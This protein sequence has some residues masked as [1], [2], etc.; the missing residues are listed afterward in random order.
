[1]IRILQIN[2]YDRILELWKRVPGVGLSEADSKERIALFLERN[3]RL[4]FVYEEAGK[5][6]GTILCG[7][8]GRRGYIYHLAVDESYRRQGIGKS[9]VEASLSKLKEEGI[10]KCHLFVF[11]GNT[12]GQEFWDKIGWEKR[13]DILVFSKIV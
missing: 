2:D 4:S 11:Q 10:D 9:L 7:H 5:I 12:L 13:K 3:K 8:D 1:M 6:I